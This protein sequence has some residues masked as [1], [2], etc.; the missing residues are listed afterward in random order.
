M[1]VPDLVA[2]KRPR[3]THGGNVRSEVRA[4]G[5]STGL[6]RMGVWVRSFEPGCA[7]TNR[8]Y[9]EVEE[10]WAYVLA[11]TG[12]VRI[13]PLRI[14]VGAGHFVAFPPGPRPHHFVASGTEAMVLLEGGERRP[15][16]DV[17]W[18]VDEGRGWRRGEL[19]DMTES[20]PPE[21]G[22][23]GQCVHLD[24]VAERDFQHAVDPGARRVM[25]SL[26]RAAG[27]ARQAVRWTRVRVGDR[28]TAYHTH[29]RTDEWVYILAGHA[30][31]RVGD[32][33]FEVF[34]G[35]FLG[36]P[37]G[38]PPHVMEPIEELTY[39]MGGQVDSDD[40][41]TYPEAGIVKR[42]GRIEP[43]DAGP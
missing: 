20:P 9:H 1:H 6:T 40:V 3:F 14:D 27:L 4:V 24:D 7:G 39:L 16:E 34:A 23:R 17:G 33:D 31:V 22:D 36:H 38:S 37:A 18:Y 35:D 5:N 13:G 12:I 26:S 2:E 28:S 41:V 32:D 11:G 10:E 42:R 21:E 15:Q 8:H 29:D 43:L 19:V 30:R 25:R